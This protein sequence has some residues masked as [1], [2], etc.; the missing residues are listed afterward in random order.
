[1]TNKYMNKDHQPPS[2]PFGALI[3]NL[4]ELEIADAANSLLSLTIDDLEPYRLEF[5]ILATIA[6]GEMA[7]ES[8]LSRQELEIALGLPPATAYRYLLDGRA[9]PIITTN[10]PTWRDRFHNN[11]HKVYSLARPSE[12]PR[13]DTAQR[14]EILRLEEAV[15]LTL[16]SDRLFTTFLGAIGLGLSD[17]DILDNVLDNLAWI[18]SVVHEAYQ[19]LMK[20]PN[21]E[22]QAGYRLNPVRD[23]LWAMNLLFENGRYSERGKVA[24]KVYS[25]YWRYRIGPPPEFEGKKEMNIFLDRL[26]NPYIIKYKGKKVKIKW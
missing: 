16:S 19:G 9:S 22:Q 12:N 21:I 14:E 23:V 10:K 20:I 24:L 5:K 4:T 15:I 3:T 6:F 7:T 8:G 13:Y 18:N 17:P 2:D 11:R 1:M 26:K 25:F